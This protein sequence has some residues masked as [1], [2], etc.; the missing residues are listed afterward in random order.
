[1]NCGRVAGTGAALVVVGVFLFLLG[2]FVWT[3][4][5]RHGAISPAVYGGPCVSIAG[6]VLLIV[7]GIGAWKEG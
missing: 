7:A 3:N 2:A 6:V 1:M 4:N 5:A